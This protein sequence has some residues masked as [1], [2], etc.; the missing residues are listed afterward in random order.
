M[1][2]I[3]KL[4]NSTEYFVLNNESD[5]VVFS[6]VKLNSH[7]E[8]IC[9]SKNLYEALLKRFVSTLKK[10]DFTKSFQKYK[11]FLE[12][13]EKKLEKSLTSITAL[14]NDPQKKEKEYRLAAELLISQSNHK[15]KGL[16][17]IEL[18]NY[19]GEKLIIKLEKNLTIMEN[20]E[21][22]YDKSQKV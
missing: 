2:Y 3:S 17:E 11:E 1:I 7:S 6:L 18:F 13:S 5:E 20:A 4:E 12:H 15:V 10:Q 14:N 19:S 22:Y 9:Q 16:N 8:I 21:K